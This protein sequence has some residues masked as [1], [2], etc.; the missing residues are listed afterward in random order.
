MKLSNACS[1][2]QEMHLNS[3]N[4]LAI[5]FKEVLSGYNLKTSQ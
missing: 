2:K 1:L 4:I 3:K 5:T